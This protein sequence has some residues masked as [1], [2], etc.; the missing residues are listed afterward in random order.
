LSDGGLLLGIPFLI[1][2]GV[3]IGWAVRRL[4]ALISRSTRA[5]PV[6]F[7]VVSA[8]VATLGAFAH[9]AV[10]AEW[11][12]PAAM[13]EGAL[14]LA[15]I[16]PL[17][18]RT[19]GRRPVAV[20]AVASAIVVALLGV[21]VVA[22]H[23]WQIDQPHLSESNR[24]LLAHADTMF[25]DYRPAER[26]LR[27]VVNGRRSAAPDEVQRAIDLT[28]Q[29]AEID[30]HLSLLRVAAGASAGVTPDSIER[31]ERILQQ[32][33]GSRS[34]YVP[35]L[36]QIMITAGRLDLARAELRRDVAMQVAARAANPNLLIELRIWAARLGRGADYA[37]LVDSVVSYIGGGAQAVPA[38][39]VRCA[40][41]TRVTKDGQR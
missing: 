1:A 26:L 11:T 29:P 22:L 23:Q 10:D 38:P 14:L 20:S 27:D 31:A 37:C 35:G 8:A 5:G 13:V 30:I 33:H 36:A 12:Y 21:N 6:D 24:T 2:V 17:R 41:K 7:V 39:D 32:V 4:W 28:E 19:T 40:S 15:C 18:P 16:A 34:P 25:G 3:A 9:S